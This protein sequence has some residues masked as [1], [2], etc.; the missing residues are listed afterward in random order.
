MKAISF[1]FEI[2]QPMR[3]KRYRFFD[4][5]ND[6]Y[7]YDDFLN[8][9]IITRLGQQSY[10]PAA[11]T[12]L[13]MIEESKGKFRCS[14]S[15]S[16]TAIE[17]FEQ[18][19]PEMID[20][21][22]KLADTGA[23]EFLATT[24]AHSLAS[25]A[26]PDEF[27]QQVKVQC[28]RIHE[29]FGVTPK[30]L[31]NT[32][33]IYDDELAPQIVDMGFKACLTE[34][35]KHILGWKSPNYVYSA[36]SAPKLK[37][38]LK[39]SKLSDDIAVR[40]ADGM[41]TE[42]PLTADKYMSWIAETPD[43]EQVVNICL[44][45]ET[46]GGMLPANTGIFQFMEALPR[47]AADKGVEFL[48]PS[49]IAQKL[50]A[51]DSLSVVH[52]ISGADEARDV[53]AWLG[54]GLQNEAFRKLYSVAERVR[55]CYDRRLK[56]DWW[57]LQCSD[58]F[59]YMSTKHFADGEAHSAFSPYETP[60]LAFT[61]Y[62]NALSDFIVRVEEQYPLSIE[63]EELNSLLTTI[64]NQAREIETLN[65]ELG[66]MRKNIEQYEAPAQEEA[67]SDKAAKATKPK[68]AKKAK[69]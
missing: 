43:E 64:R 34:G 50:K 32:E 25:L 2:H 51:V 69:K 37:L 45:I 27:R 8:D 3:L 38:L 5:G 54:N 28:E 65:K 14:I 52:P 66:S 22:K 47:F 39:N 63:N 6:H 57:Y 35:A 58:H 15:I 17:Q 13:K 9:D 40:F 26:D 24:Y 10:L 36:A 49:Q 68:A 33:L 67:A 1:N 21:L 31:H 29:L 61:N 60:F 62:M 59:Y 42:F 44:N 53:S 41:W 12:L 46:L 11:R 16:G 18:Y 56:Q 30:V 20:A 48:T 4:I 23:V 7:Y 19:V 55:L